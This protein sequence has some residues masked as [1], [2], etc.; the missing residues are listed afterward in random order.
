MNKVKLSIW[1][2]ISIVIAIATLFG[3]I[4]TPIFAAQSEVE[5]VWQNRKKKI[6]R[7][8]KENVYTI[9][10]FR[11][12]STTDL[13]READMRALR[14]DRVE[15]AKERRGGVMMRRLLHGY[16]ISGLIKWL[17]FVTFFYVLGQYGPRW[18]RRW[19]GKV[20]TLPTTGDRWTALRA[21]WR[22][23]LADLA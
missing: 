10:N 6:D 23:V 3:L 12:Y 18:W 9:R 7:Q 19:K 1:Q 4:I 13:E 8:Y 16:Y 22:S 11:N 20:N 14:I 2:Q 15:E 21:R 5:Q 17:C